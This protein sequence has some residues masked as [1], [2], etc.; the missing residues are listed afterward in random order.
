MR[1]P[2]R[3]LLPQKAAPAGGF[4]TLWLLHGYSDNE[5]AWGR[6]TAIGRY[7]EGLDLAVV[8]ACGQKSFYHNMAHG[9]RF[10]DF[11]A[12]ELP[13]L[14]RAALPL[15]T[16]RNGNFIAGNSM[17]GYGAFM[18]ALRRPLQYEAAVSF[19]GAL[20]ICNYVP[21]TARTNFDLNGM[22][23]FGTEPWVALDYDL[24]AL[25]PSAGDLRLYACC[26][27]EDFL[28]E[29]NRAFASR[30]AEVGVPLEYVEDGGVHDW[31]YWDAHLPWALER[32]LHG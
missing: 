26:G 25:L 28:I 15:A 19:S 32:L 5:G 10:F 24:F 20:D 3:V 4:A 29:D 2:V 7:A 12:D 27:T 8:M 31:D 21:W 22:N 1:V 6:W 16:G 18:L 14:L 9:D 11:F 23:V 30:A 13:A 17:G